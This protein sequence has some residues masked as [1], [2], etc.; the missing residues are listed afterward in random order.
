MIER[1]IFG[2]VIFLCM[3]T[4][5]SQETLESFKKRTENYYHYLTT[6][7]VNNF[8]CKISS[9]RFIN[10]I[11]N[12][13]DSS[14]YYPLKFI[15][16]RDGGSY[17]V[18]QPFPQLS[19]SLRRE[20]LTQAQLLKNLFGD[21]FFD[22]QKFYIKHPTAQIAVNATL[23]FS[24]DTIF[25]SAT[26]EKQ[27]TLVETYTRGGQLGRAAWKFADQQVVS[28]P[29]FTELENKWICLGWQNQVYEGMNIVSG[30]AAQLEYAPAQGRL[31]PTRISLLLQQR[32]NPDAKVAAGSYTI[33]IKDFVFNENITELPAPETSGSAPPQQ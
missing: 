18:L 26:N 15:W 33:Y 5:F 28:Y 9:G 24:A 1:I 32:K 20:A 2:L 19:D 17:Y 23:T 10:F 8:T 3:A 21:L 11:K 31:L 27:A 7:D 13:A 4:G 29:M 14:F 25:I 12:K 30:T 22:L 16:T 6:A